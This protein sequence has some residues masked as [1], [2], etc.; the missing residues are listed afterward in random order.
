MP[1]VTQS[2]TVSQVVAIG[3]FAQGIAN[4]T[5]KGS[6]VKAEKVSANHSLIIPIAYGTTSGTFYIPEDAFIAH[7]WFRITTSFGGGAAFDLGSNALIAAASAPTVTTHGTAGST[8]YDYKVV[9][10]DP[11][12]T[13]SAAS[14]AGPVTT[15]NATLSATNYNVL[16]LTAVTGAA[17]YNIYRT[18]GG[19]TQG[20]IGNTTSLTFNDTGLTGDGST[21]PSSGTSGVDIVNAQGLTASAD[22]IPVNNFAVSAI[23]NWAGNPMGVQALT[24]GITGSPVAGAGYLII[25]YFNTIFAP[26]QV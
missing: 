23:Q 26:Q 18:V 7:A 3:G 17:S 10:I 9:A 2:G 8:T 20:L 19:A 16:T 5:L 14:S 24:Y 21:A 4:P 22:V 15:G 13:Y 1:N 25:Q 11:S 12:G 6:S